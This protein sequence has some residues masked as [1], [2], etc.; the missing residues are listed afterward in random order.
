MH[1]VDGGR[2]WLVQSPDLRGPEAQEVER[3]PL[4]LGLR[5]IDPRVCEDID[6]SGC[7]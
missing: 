4:D 1:D 5:P 7:V 2:A 3:L 6:V